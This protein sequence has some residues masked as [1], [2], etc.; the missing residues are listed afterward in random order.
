MTVINAPPN[1]TIDN[2]K[3]RFRSQWIVSPRYDLIFFIGSCSLTF[4]FWGLYSWMQQVRPWNIDSILL[5]YFVF[6]AFFDHPH[7]FQT[8]SRTHLD[9][10]EFKK[11]RS[12]HTWG[13]IGL[14]LLGFVVIG[15]G[16]EAE[17]IVFAS[18]LG[19][20]H[21]IRQHYGFLKAYKNLNRDRHRIDDWLDFGLFNT[22]MY[23]CF[24]YDYTEV[25]N[26]VVIYGNLQ[27]AF[28]NLPPIIF[29]TI[30]HLFLLFL[31]L[32]IARQLHH[33]WHRRA[34]NLPKLLFLFA[35]LATHHFVFFATA[36]PFLVA[37]SL[38]TAYHNIQYQGW[39]AHYQNQRF[40]GVKHLALKW[41]AVA[42]LYGLFVGAIEIFGLLDQGWGLWLF[43]PFTMV[44]IY[45]YI[46]DG[47]IWKFSQ[48]PELRCLFFSPQ[49][50]PSQQS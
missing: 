22:G 31:L 18:V 40:S 28:P 30:Q 2:S 5:T 24:F 7:I 33:L 37:E 47:F 17:L 11:R 4:A 26:P 34:L 35:S 50:N 9:E 21:I 43:V 38:E 23:A 3:S 48:Q 16:R 44:V 19:S 12:M 20:Y 39:M 13:L 42:M 25:G 36:T 45:H 8:F 15:M 27:S 32:F 41:L 14:I 10:I 6:T 29:E 46:V 49:S 1:A